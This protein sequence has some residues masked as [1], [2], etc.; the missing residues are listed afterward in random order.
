MWNL[1][2]HPPDTK[3]SRRLTERSS[4]S[5]I[6]AREGLS[7]KWERIETRSPSFQNQE[8]P[9]VNIAIFLD[10]R[11]PIPNA[12]ADLWRRTHGRSSVQRDGPRQ[13]NSRSIAARTDQGKIQAPDNLYAL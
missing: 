10:L 2:R 5:A 13:R 3:V 9:G 4:D 8:A 6:P 1:L 12:A 11:Y 7:L